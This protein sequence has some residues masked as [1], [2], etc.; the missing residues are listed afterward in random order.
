MFFAQTIT[1]AQVAATTVVIASLP[2]IPRCFTLK[3][4]SILIIKQRQL[5][6]RQ[7]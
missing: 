4:R 5:D 6:Q 3:C 1:A 2:Q 7:E